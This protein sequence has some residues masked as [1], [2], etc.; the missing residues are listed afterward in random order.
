M[1]TGAALGERSIADF[2]AY[3]DGER[4]AHGVGYHA[5]APAAAD[6]EG[7]EAAQK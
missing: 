2:R 1:R 6:A 5:A 7:D 4:D 3:L